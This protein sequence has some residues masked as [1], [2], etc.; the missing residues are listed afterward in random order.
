MRLIL[1][2][3]FPSILCW[4]FIYFVSETYIFSRLQLHL[5]TLYNQC[6]FL[7]LF[8]VWHYY[9][10]QYADKT[11]TLRKSMS[12]RS[13]RAELFCI[14][15]LK[16]SYFF[17]YFV[18]TSKTLSV[19]MIYLSAYNV[20]TDLQMYRQNSEKALLGGGQPPPPPPAPLWLR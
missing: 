17:Q 19:Q 7:S 12:E 1:K 4:Y 6:S 3:L 5:H 8:M 2:L 14:F 11:L 18:G 9:T 16:K 20:P 10:R 13:E 15:T